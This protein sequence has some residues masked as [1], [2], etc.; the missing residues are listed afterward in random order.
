MSTA[1]VRNIIIREAGKF[2]ADDVFTRMLQRSVW[3]GDSC[4]PILEWAGGCA[5]WR[6]AMHAEAGAWIACYLPNRHTDQQLLEQ[7]AAHQVA[8][9]LEG[10]EL[11][12]PGLIARGSWPDN[13]GKVID[14]LTYP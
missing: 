3:V 4:Q 5:R 11:E 6:C 13:L 9:R 1:S 8:V 12:R 14:A 10:G 2:L 7:F